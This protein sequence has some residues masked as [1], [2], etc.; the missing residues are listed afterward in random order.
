M[1]PY[2]LENLTR[3]LQEAAYELTG[4]DITQIAAT[5][6]IDQSTVREYLKGNIAKPAIG[7]AILKRARELN[8]KKNKVA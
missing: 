6:L 7:T 1:K 4:K 5:E 2:N 3:G 8:I